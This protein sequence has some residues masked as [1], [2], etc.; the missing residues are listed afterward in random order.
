VATISFATLES[1][2]LR[3]KGVIG[4]PYPFLDTARQTAETIQV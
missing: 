2:F 1:R 3:L 4:K